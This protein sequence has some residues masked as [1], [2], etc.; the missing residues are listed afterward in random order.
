MNPGFPQWR[1]GFFMNRRGPADGG[2]CVRDGFADGDGPSVPV[3]A[4]VT[5]MMRGHGRARPDNRMEKAR[6]E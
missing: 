2:G 6:L 3:A 4:D 1:P 5:A